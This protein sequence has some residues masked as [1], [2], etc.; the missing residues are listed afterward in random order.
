MMHNGV[1]IILVRLPDG[2]RQL[3]ITVFGKWPPPEEI[4]FNGVK[5]KRI[6]FSSLPDS[7][8]MQPHVARGCEYQPV[9][10]EGEGHV[11]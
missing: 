11:R 9:I 6:R 5:H 1:E 7:A 2:T 8:A 3:P 4:L 10:M